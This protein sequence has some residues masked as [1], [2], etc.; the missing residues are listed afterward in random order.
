MAV[1]GG[2]GGNEEKS[3]S[4]GNGGISPVVLVDESADGGV[5]IGA[6]SA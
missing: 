2:N 6:V 3:G 5:K 1:A 4:G